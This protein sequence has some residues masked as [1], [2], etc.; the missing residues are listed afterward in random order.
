[1]PHESLPK[2]DTSFAP[3]FDY[4]TTAPGVYKAM[5]ALDEYVAGSDLDSSLVLL[6]QLYVSQINGCAYCV[7]M[8]WKQLKAA[9]ESDVR[10][11]SL[12]VWRESPYYSERERA[13]LRWAED[14]TLVTRDHVADAV[15]REISPH[16]SERGLADLTLAIVA[17]NGWNR[18]SIAA[19]LLPGSFSVAT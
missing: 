6:I 19:R 13:A 17:I 9:G 16:F 5:D 15:Y 18:L 4:K 11:Y 14:V 1:M 8:H 2:K 7:D 3:R 10:L 12:S